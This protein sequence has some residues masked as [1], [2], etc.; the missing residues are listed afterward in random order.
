[1]NYR[2]EA[3]AS[4][5]VALL[6]VF[7]PAFINVNP[8][9]RAQ[10]QETSTDESETGLAPEF[11]L[12]EELVVGEPVEFDASA[13]E[14]SE[15]IQQYE[16]DFT[17]DGEFTYVSQDPV[18]QYTYEEPGERTVTLRINDQEGNTAEASSEVTVREASSGENGE[19]ETSDDG[20]FETFGSDED[21]ESRDEETPDGP[22]VSTVFVEED[23]RDALNEVALQTGVNIIYD[24]T[25]VG[26]VTLDLQEVP[27]EK[28]LEMMLV[29]GGYTYHKVDDYYLVGLPTPDSPMFEEITV[30]ETIR[31]DYL[32]ADQAVQL[33]PPFYENFV[34]TSSEHDQVLTISAPESVIEEFKKDLAKID[35]SPQG[36]LVEVVVTEVSTD[37]IENYGSDLFGLTVS[38]G[39]NDEPF[40]TYSLEYDGLMALEAAGPI[41]ELMASLE[42]LEEEGKA[43]IKANPKIRVGDGETANLFLGEERVLVLERDEADNVTRDIEVGMIMEVTPRIMAEDEVRL[44]IAPDVSHFTKE[45]DNQLIV[46]RNELQ[47]VVRAKDGETITM[48]GMTLDEVMEYESTVPILG[49]IP[50]LR[51]LFRKETK[52]KG[53]REMLVLITPKIISK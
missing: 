40:D 8:G 47:S 29:S 42:A 23:I 41:G 50:L 17:N 10:D 20:E 45:A 9:V 49:D 26:T 13:S 4:L 2:L 38:E 7:S 12:P 48:A 5:L 22:T 39:E 3:A 24:E 14:P 36:I 44:D 21:S 6:L 28:A 51:W 30:T 35:T 1:M 53:E 11:S 15:E 37:V 46:R 16:W 43:E 33:L 27:L 34:R 52:K 25:V 31:L 18:A 19:E 32:S